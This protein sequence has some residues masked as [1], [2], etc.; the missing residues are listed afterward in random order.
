MTGV[1][2]DITDFVSKWSLTMEQTDLL[3]SA[4]L[5]EVATNFANEWSN[6]AGK[7]LKQ[8]KQEYQ[9]AIYINQ[10]DNYNIIVGLNGTLPNMIEKGADPFD[11]KDGFKES[12]KKK[13]KKGGGWYLTIPFR[14]ATPTSV[15]ESA[16]FSN[17]MPQEVYEVAKKLGDRE[18]IKIKDLP[19]QFQIPQMRKSLPQFG[20]YIHKNPIHEA[21]QKK[22]DS[23]GR[24]QYVSFR[25]VSD[26][27]DE[28]SWI[29]TG[30]IARNLAE[31]ALNSFDI[32]GSIAKVKRDFY[33]NFLS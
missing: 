1:S 11:M 24:S 3:A 5:S 12:S 8:T 26:L 29:H 23:T 30:I 28:N 16:I 21:I 14:F 18:Q 15:A 17:K 7:E 27:S 25:R 33:Q 6:I 2:I 4:I 22:Q 13:S 10:I 9:K 32:E 31:K 20:D 19:V